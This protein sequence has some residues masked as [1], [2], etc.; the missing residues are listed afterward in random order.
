VHGLLGVG[1]VEATGKISRA[2]QDRTDEELEHGR[3][4]K[5]EPL[6]RG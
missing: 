5:R 3:P 2:H 6:K 1:A 4:D